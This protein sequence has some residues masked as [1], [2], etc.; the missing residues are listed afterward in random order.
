VPSGKTSAVNIIEGGRTNAG[1]YSAAWRK[2]RACRRH[3]PLE[4][5]RLWHCVYETYLDSLPLVGADLIERHLR[6]LR[7]IA[8]KIAWQRSPKS[9]SIWSKEAEPR[10]SHVSLAH[11]LAAFGV[12]GLYIAA[13]RYNPS[14]GAFSTYANYWV[15]KF[16]R[17]YLD[18]IIGTIPRTGHMGDDLPRRSVMDLVDA[19]LDRK[20][21]YRGKA[22][23]PVLFDY[24]LT[25]FFTPGDDR[26]EFEI[27]SDEGPTDPTR[28]DY[29]QRRVGIKDFPWFDWGT[30]FTPR[31]ALPGHLGG[32]ASAEPPREDSYEPR[33][34]DLIT[35]PEQ[36]V[37]YD[38]TGPGMYLRAGTIDVQHYYGSVRVPSVLLHLCTGKRLPKKYPRTDV[39]IRLRPLPPCRLMRRKRPEALARFR[40]PPNYGD[41]FSGD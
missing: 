26:D 28:L 13:D 22:A 16:I 14:M 25:S 4:D 35:L 11:E 29:L 39:R 12:F 10:Q 30:Y 24:G 7:P 18:E 32:R 17:L 21:L 27:V 15:K 31:L 1:L 33:E 19:A 23:S 9:F 36:P 41:A 2:V 40:R 6:I 8:F 37:P 20:R 34:L 38:H 5:E 3:R